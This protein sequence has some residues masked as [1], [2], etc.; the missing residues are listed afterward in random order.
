VVEIEVEDLSQI[1]R[2]RSNYRSL[3]PIWG[4]FS[5]EDRG[6]KKRMIQEQTQRA[7]IAIETEAKE[8]AEE[9]A[10]QR[11]VLKAKLE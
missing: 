11:P 3:N 8:E 4:S 6:K 1:K 7:E 10:E 5:E 9:E 2:F